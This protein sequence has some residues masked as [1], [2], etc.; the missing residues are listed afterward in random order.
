M[1]GIEKHLARYP[2]LY[3]RVGFVH[4]F[5][6]LRAEEIRRLLVEHGLAIGLIPPTSDISDQEAIAAIIRITGGNFRLLR[7]LLS[8]IGGQHRI[9]R[10]YWTT[11]DNSGSMFVGQESGHFDAHWL[12]S[13]Q[14]PR[15]GP[16]AVT[17]CSRCG[18]MRSGFRRPRLRSPG[19]SPWPA[20]GARSRA[21]RRRV[22]RLET[23]PSWPFAG[24]SH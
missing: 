4:A 17:R 21:R 6:T 7:W 20:A 16:G 22:G 18:G 10:Q 8:Q 15:P 13:R 3:S 24:T 14:H 19:R 23:R 12:R 9:V 11:N 5:R 2:Q 1:P